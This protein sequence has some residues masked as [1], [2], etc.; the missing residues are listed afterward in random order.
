MRPLFDLL[1]EE[2][3][4]FANGENGILIGGDMM[5]RERYEGDAHAKGCMLRDSW[6]MEVDRS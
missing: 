3:R 6:G 1:A 5:I 4:N 2:G